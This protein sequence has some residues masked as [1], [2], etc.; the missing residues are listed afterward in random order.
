MYDYTYTW[1]N[2]IY[3]CIHTHT[4]TG[5]NELSDLWGRL[6]EEKER[7]LSLAQVCMYVSVYVCVTHTWYTYNQGLV[8]YMNESCHTWMSHVT[9]VND[10]SLHRYSHDWRIN[11]KWLCPRCV[12]TPTRARTHAHKHT[13]RYR[14][15][16]T[17]TNWHTRHKNKHTRTKIHKKPTNIRTHSL[18]RY[19][20][21]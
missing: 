20:C 11:Y 15:T 5:K 7:S 8:K 4:Q 6:V 13:Y 1:I 12:Y 14:I 9:H 2:S 16:H 17:Q 18:H 3:I 19:T 10:S 21:K